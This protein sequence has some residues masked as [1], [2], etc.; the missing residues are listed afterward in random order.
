MV[1]SLI[2]LSMAVMMQVVPAWQSSYE[3]GL[4]LMKAGAYQAA[5][6]EF[7]QA[8]AERPEEELSIPT[9]EV[10]S[11]D[12]LP[13]LYLAITAYHSSDLGVARDRLADADA[14]GVAAGSRFGGPLLEHY[15]SLIDASPAP[16]DRGSDPDTGIDLDS[17]RSDKR[18]P[19]V[20]TDEEMKRLRSTTMIRCGLASDTDASSAPWYFHYELGLEL[21]GSG[22]PQ[23]ALDSLLAAAERKPLPKEYARMYGMWFIRYRPYLELADNHAALGNW[24]CAFN[25]L[26]ISEKSGE[27]QS[28]D[29]ETYARFRSLLENCRTNLGEGVE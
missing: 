25:A 10:H 6:R 1:C 19:G 4:A 28:D 12:Y 20:L 15:R 18:H 5:H 21:A 7:E 11:L 3:E 17:V 8:L 29:D 23:R 24:R 9:G 2:S 16:R 22:D 26:Q 14:S 13:H 27:V